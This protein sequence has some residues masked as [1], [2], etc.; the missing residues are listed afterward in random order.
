MTCTNS[1]GSNNNLTGYTPQESSF[2][3]F[4]LLRIIESSI[5]S[6][7]AVNLAE[8]GL[9]SLAGAG[10]AGNVGQLI[11]LLDAGQTG[12]NALSSLL[13]DGYNSPELQHEILANLFNTS[14]SQNGIDFEISPASVSNPTV[15]HAFVDLMQENIISNPNG[16]SLNLDLDGNGRWDYLDLLEV[17]KDV[18][19]LEDNA[20]FTGTLDDILD[21]FTGPAA[22]NNI[23]PSA[24]LCDDNVLYI[25]DLLDPTSF[26][27]LM[28]GSG[29]FQT[30]V[31]YDWVLQSQNWEIIHGNG[32]V[33]TGTHEWWQVIPNF[34]Q[35]YV[36]ALINQMTE[37][38]HHDLI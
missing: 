35:H 38:A 30:T 11:S 1:N 19:D 16:V 12:L 29:V 32:W 5:R 21:L 22:D 18:F 10:T 2:I 28:E 20:S 9:W 25:E 14:M 27:N 24:N 34:D 13:G 26:N 4:E 3:A 15:L 31:S 17:Q 37:E 33:T 36:E 7:N 6:S 8:A 23:T